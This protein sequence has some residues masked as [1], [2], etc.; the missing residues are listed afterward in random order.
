MLAEWTPLSDAAKE[1]GLNGQK[2][3]YYVF[4]VGTRPGNRKKGLCSAMIKQYQAR[5]ASDGLPIWLEATT[6]Y[7]MNL[8]SRLGFTVVEEM[9]LGKGIASPDG[10]EYKGGEGLKVWAMVWQPP[11]KAVDR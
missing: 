10:T 2:R 9:V 1:K 7:S 4:F 8:Y 5:A 11:T 6:P 3:Y